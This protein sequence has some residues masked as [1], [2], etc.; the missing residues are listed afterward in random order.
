MDN[1]DRL[2]RKPKTPAQILGRILRDLREDADVTQKTLTDHLGF[3]HNSVMS[4][5]ERGSR[6]IRLWEFVE[7]CQFLGADPNEVLDQYL[8]AAPGSKIPPEREESKPK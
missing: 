1:D 7:V 2:R 3:G 6:S 5:V 8:K 4:T